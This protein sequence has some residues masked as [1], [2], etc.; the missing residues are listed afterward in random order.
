MLIRRN[1]IVLEENSRFISFWTI[2]AF[3]DTCWSAR[4]PWSISPPS[5]RPRSS[6]TAT[7][8]FGNYG[9]MR[10]KYWTL[11]CF[12]KIWSSTPTTSSASSSST[13]STA[14]SSLSRWSSHGKRSGRQ[15]Q[16]RVFQTCRK[17]FHWSHDVM[18]SSLLCQGGLVTHLPRLLRHFPKQK[19]E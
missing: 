14:S 15:N 16:P 18:C 4:W 7:I 12:S 19:S 9:N 5:F 2:F 10:K 1:L 3:I 6:S 17:E 8:C 13:S 11:N